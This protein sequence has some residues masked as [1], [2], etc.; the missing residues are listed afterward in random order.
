ML[1]PMTDEEL[2]LFHK[3]SQ[4]IYILKQKRKYKSNSDLQ[5]IEESIFNLLDDEIENLFDE[6]EDL[7][8]KETWV[9]CHPM[10]FHISEFEEA[11][12][13]QLDF[14]QKA[15]QDEKVKKNT[16]V[17]WV[18]QVDREIKELYE[19]VNKSNLNE[20]TLE[21]KEEVFWITHP[22]TY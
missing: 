5:K 8:I 19:R 12:K 2:E 6:Y 3:R 20:L 4:I 21:E 17:E 9:D 11:L 7:I 18:Q 15:I 1:I 13:G 14:I 22:I 16:R 10:F